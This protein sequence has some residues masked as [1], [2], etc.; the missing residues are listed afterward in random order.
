MYIEDIQKR[1]AL[2]ANAIVEQARIVRQA[3]YDLCL[4][5][6]ER[7]AAKGQDVASQVFAQ[8]RVDH[9]AAVKQYEEDKLLRMART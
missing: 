4:A 2:D 3:L 7:V 8:D 6:D 5:C 1:T 9:A